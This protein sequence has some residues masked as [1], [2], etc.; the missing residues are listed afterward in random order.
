VEENLAIFE[1]NGSHMRGIANN[2]CIGS[3]V[4]FPKTTTYPKN[5]KWKKKKKEKKALVNEE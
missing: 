3:L 1:T 5:K 2:L 4:V